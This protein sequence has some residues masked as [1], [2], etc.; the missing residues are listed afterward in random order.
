MSHIFLKWIKDTSAFSYLWK[1]AQ[2][3]HVPNTPFLPVHWCVL[4]FC[5]CVTCLPEVILR[6]L[7]ILLP[8]RIRS[9]QPNHYIGT[10]TSSSCVASTRSLPVN[11][12]TS[13]TPDTPLDLVLWTTP[14]L[15]HLRPREWLRVL[16]A[17]MVYLKTS[18][19]TCT[20]K[21]YS[22]KLPDISGENWNQCVLVTWS[23]LDRTRC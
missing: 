8:L 19:N 17:I 2:I 16:L 15:P 6:H 22:L 12:L 10:I 21:S 20:S 7:C 4:T 23:T 18:D 1:V 14:V 13:G 11:Y 5:I 9:N 3:C